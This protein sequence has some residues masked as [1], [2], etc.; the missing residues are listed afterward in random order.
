MSP[1]LPPLDEA[2]ELAQG[3]AGVFSHLTGGTYG[4]PARSECEAGETLVA[5]GLGNPVAFAH[6]VIDWYA[7]ATGD[8]LHGAGEMS[9]DHYNLVFSSAALARS[10]CEYAGI[11][12][13]LAEPGVPVQIRV[14]RTAWLVDKSFREAKALPVPD[15]FQD[16]EARNT[17]LLT[18]ARKN[19]SAKEKLPGPT[20]RFEAMNPYHGKA[21]YAYYS[22][23]AHGNLI[24]TGNLI[25][26]QL[27]DR[28]QQIPDFWWRIVLACAQALNL[29]T[30]ISDLRDR[31]PN[32][33]VRMY[34]LQRQYSALMDEYAA[35]GGA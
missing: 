14:A 22:M 4:E 29:A 2:V 8:L 28:T 15:E 1:D 31:K 35:S 19:T 24:T 6:V 20:A 23:L 34:G 33:L 10:A 7:G 26:G 18:W 32:E 27:T 3:V 25:N 12:W 11:G 13:W 30:R 9:H 5:E 21:N 17:I 16:F